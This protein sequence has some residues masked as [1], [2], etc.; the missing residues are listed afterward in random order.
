MK[1]IIRIQHGYKTIFMSVQAKDE[2]DAIRKAKRNLDC[3]SHDSTIIY[4]SVE[5]VDPKN[6]KNQ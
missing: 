4:D 2:N 3:F 1:F 6:D 5:I